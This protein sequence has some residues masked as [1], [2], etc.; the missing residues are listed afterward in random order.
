MRFSTLLEG[1][2]VLAV[3][4]GA[5]AAPKKYNPASTAKT[6]AIAK[7]ALATLTEYA[8]NNPNPGACTIKTAAKRREWG[9]MC[10]SER[11]AYVAAVNCLMSKPSKLDPVQVPGAKSRYDD[12]VAVHIN[13]TF[14][15]H[16]TANFLSWH[17][18]YLWSFEQALR[19]ECG[20]K[21]WQ[22]YWNWGKWAYDPINS[23][24]FDGSD[25]S[26]SGNGVYAPHGCTSTGVG[27]VEPGNG[28]GCVDSGPF[29]DMVVNLGPAGS[30]FVAD[31]P[32]PDP[33]GGLFGHNPR[34]LRRDI[35]VETSSR[36]TNDDET[37]DLLANYG[38]NIVQFQ[39]RMQGDF[40]NGYYGVHTGGHYTLNGDPS[41]DFF[42][43]PGDPAFWLHHGQID[44]VWWMWQNQQPETRT[45]A[46]GGTITLFNTPPSREG[47]LDDLLDMYVLGESMEIEKVMSSVGM[48]GGPLCYVYI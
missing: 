42:V 34:C 29:K 13:Q 39:D 1:G 48:T 43:S 2:L 25:T 41:S 37:Y 38:A 36:W 12:F 7:E 28:G 47:R 3:A 16:A 45:S 20:Y 23:P 9:S 14:S 17:R 10:K 8:A 22:P 46:I 18:L 40:A 5:A 19:N 21:G 4:G 15:I 6:D 31:P 32:I 27:C 11:R 35:S 33:V 30:G 26:L 24:L 44:R